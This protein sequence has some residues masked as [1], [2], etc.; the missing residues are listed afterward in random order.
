MLYTE[1]Y[2][3]KIFLKT[4]APW[5]DQFSDEAHIALHKR[6][7]ADLSLPI[8]PKCTSRLCDRLAAV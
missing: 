8:R 7:I 3:T 1:A 4:A 6:T 5:T 2:V